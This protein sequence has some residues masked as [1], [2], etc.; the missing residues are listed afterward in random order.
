MWEGDQKE[1][2]VWLID[3]NGHATATCGIGWNAFI[4]M[5]NTSCKW[6]W[7]AYMRWVRKTLSPLFE[8]ME[9][10]NDEEKDN[11]PP[12][13]CPEKEKGSRSVCLLF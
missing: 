5:R 1:V 9:G 4:H 2:T 8:V 3:E 10:D 6:A 11:E 7:V 13:A 12:P